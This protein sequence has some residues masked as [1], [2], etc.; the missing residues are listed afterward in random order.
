LL[1]IRQTASAR[2]AKQ[3]QFARTFAQNS[4]EARLTP[5]KNRLVAG[6]QF[7]RLNQIQRCI[8]HSSF[9][10]QIKGLL[11]PANTTDWNDISVATCTQDDPMS[12]TKTIR[13]ET[14]GMAPLKN[15]NIVMYC[16]E[17]ALLKPALQMNFIASQLTR[18]R[19]HIYGDVWICRSSDEHG[20]DMSLVDA[21]HTLQGW[22]GYQGSG[23][24]LRSICR[25]EEYTQVRVQSTDE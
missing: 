6:S 2:N 12:V 20:H 24:R 8:A 13:C 19:Q 22:I 21:T 10:M 9:A 25:E 1:L 15:P 18:D 23:S 11:V 17:E 14:L 5:L 4:S 7:T 16:D 3:V